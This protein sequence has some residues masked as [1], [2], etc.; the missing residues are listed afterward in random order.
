MILKEFPVSIKE[1]RRKKLI[2]YVCSFLENGNVTDPQYNAVLRATLEEC[3]RNNM[4][5][6]TIDRSI[7]RA[8]RFYDNESIYCE[9][10]L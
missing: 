4:P 3:R 6:E 9:N 7:K 1:N 5:K 8:V 10:K 2:N